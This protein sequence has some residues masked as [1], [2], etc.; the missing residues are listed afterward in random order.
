MSAFTLRG[1][2]VRRSRPD[3]SQL[4]QQRLRSDWVKKVGRHRSLGSYWWNSTPITASHPISG[5]VGY[6]FWRRLRLW[7]KRLTDMTS[8]HKAV[9]NV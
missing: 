3:A 4:Q 8:S 1:G 9:F 7:T 5:A 2:S 6:I